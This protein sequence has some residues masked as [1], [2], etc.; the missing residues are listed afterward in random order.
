MKRGLGGLR[1]LTALGNHASS[2]KCLVILTSGLWI[3]IVKHVILKYLPFLFA[4]FAC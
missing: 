3:V 2:A 1:I 4:C